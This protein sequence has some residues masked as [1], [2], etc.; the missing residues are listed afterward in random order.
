[1]EPT[2]TKNKGIVGRKKKVLHPQHFLQY[3]H[4]K[5]YVVNCYSNLNLLMKL[6]FIFCPPIT[7]HNNLLLMICNENV[8]NSC[9][10]V[11]TSYCCHNIFTIVEVS[12]PYKSK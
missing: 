4:N 6:F 2:T 1:M 8:V 7:T 11:K 12:I 9:E 3:F 10:N 5:S